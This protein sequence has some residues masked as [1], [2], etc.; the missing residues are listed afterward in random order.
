M[1]P[2][3]H[4]KMA[5]HSKLEELKEGIKRDNTPGS[6]DGLFS[7]HILGSENDFHWSVNVDKDWLGS[8]EET[9]LQGN[10]IQLA[11]LGYSISTEKKDGESFI[12]L[13]SLG[14]ERLNSRES[15]PGDGLSFPFYPRM[16]LGLVLGVQR[17]DSKEKEKQLNW[18]QDILSQRRAMSVIDPLQKMM[19]NIVEAALLK[20]V[21]DISPYEVK[22]FQSYDEFSLLYWGVKSGSFR[23]TDTETIRLVR[24]RVIEG[25]LEHIPR[26]HWV[27]P[28]IYYSV[29]SC[30][31]ES[32]DPTVL[33][34]SHISRLLNNFE[35]AM[36]RWPSSEKR[37]WPINDEKDIQSILWL[38]L[39][40]AF[41]DVVDEE[42]TAK[43]GHGYSLVDF[44]IP[45][46]K[47][48]IEA[49]FLR[50]RGDFKK[51]ENEIKID[52]I[53]YMKG[54][55][56][57]EMIAFIYDDSASVE[58]HETTIQGLRKIDGVR[59]VII[60]SRPSHLER[61]ER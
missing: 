18:L 38:I 14:L 13:F 39:R 58:E 24:S 20:N 27:A 7:Q 9:I 4:V 50:A 56:C 59:D 36:R 35:S 47:L 11:Q 60:V 44:R 1:V 16:F 45:S 30:L 8:N 49:K 54:I 21:I 15:F 34:P 52:S 51:I 55:D 5:F 26:E 48:L 46:L 19:F 53:N 29:R 23:L 6:L 41:D 17:L 12:R 61:I 3:T 28:I 31:L 33:S 22:Q 32:L 2:V 25:F 42:P 43:L 37:K 40:T 10:Y 57:K